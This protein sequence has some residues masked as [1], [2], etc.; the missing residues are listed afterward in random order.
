[1]EITIQE[2]TF[3]RLQRHARPLVDE[4]DTVINRALD[5]LEQNEADPAP[6]SS[7][8]PERSIDPRNLPNLKHTKVLDAS[9][10]G[11]R[12]PRANWNVLLRHMIHLGMEQLDHDYLEFVKICP[13][14]VVKG[15]KEDEGF[16][17]LSDLDVSV[18]G[19]DSNDACRAITTVAQSLKVD[20][21]IM[22]M[23]R[24]KEDAAYPGERARLLLKN[25]L[26]RIHIE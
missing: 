12:I 24:Q 11:V 13:V 15:R 19:Q 26:R 16:R 8:A 10:N 20:V 1:M 5:A 4:A 9:I 22:F 21:Q 14:R 3:A 7:V 17:Y 18:S 25:P 23:W 2:A 6:N